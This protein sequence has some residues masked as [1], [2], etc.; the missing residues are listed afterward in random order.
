LAMWIAVSRQ[1]RFMDKPLHLNNGL[2]REEAI[3]LY[4]IENAKIL[5]LE[6]Q[7]G[8]LEPGKLADFIIVDRDPLTCPE[9][10]IKDVKVHE[11]W[12]GGKRIWVR[13]TQAQN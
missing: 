9:S 7:T 2:S 4:T 6:E 13:S 5:F 11:T 1:C 3:R 10:Q 12:L 8:S